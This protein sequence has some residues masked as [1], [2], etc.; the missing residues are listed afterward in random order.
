LSVY[1]NAILAAHTQSNQPISQLRS[2]QSRSSL[3]L[4]LTSSAAANAA[5]S[6]IANTNLHLEDVPCLNTLVLQSVVEVHL[7]ASEGHT[8]F[9]PGDTVEICEMSDNE[10]WSKG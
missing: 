4:G 9:T 6:S 10:A 5:S 8:L 2:P 1:L 3:V 7:P